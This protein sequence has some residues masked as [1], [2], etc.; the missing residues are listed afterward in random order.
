MANCDVIYK[1]WNVCKDNQLSIKCASYS[2]STSFVPSAPVSLPK[3]GANNLSNN[4]D[5]YLVGI[6]QCVILVIESLW[7]WASLQKSTVFTFPFFQD[8]ETDPLV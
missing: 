2:T 5:P 1:V 6:Q 8:T 3:A 7:G 4:H